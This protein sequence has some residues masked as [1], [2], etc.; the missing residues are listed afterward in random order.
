MARSQEH[1][2]P[3]PADRKLFGDRQ[4]PGLRAALSDLCWLLDRGYASRSALTLVG[5]RYTLASRQ[6]MAIARCACSAEAVAS[7]QERQVEPESLQNEELWVDGY[8]LL[9]LL[10]SALGGSVVLLGRDGCLR[11]I[12]GVHRRYRKVSETETALRLVAETASAWGVTCCHWWL[13]KPVSNSGR[14]RSLVLDLAEKNGWEMKVDL[15][16]SPDHVLAK[17]DK[18]IA[19]ADGIVLERCQRWVNLGRWIVGNHIR[20]ANVIDLVSRADGRL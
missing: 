6:R 1:R 5:N 17:T 14:L 19:T 4:L 8:N 20:S 16:F 15:S 3:A 10:E 7:R 18:I 11:D 2:G 9:T 13:D 12:A